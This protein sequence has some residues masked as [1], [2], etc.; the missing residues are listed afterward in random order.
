MTEPL[1]P[2]EALHEAADGRLDAGA[3]AALD[4][5]LAECDA[6]RA[7]LEAIRWTKAQVA[8]ARAE[9]PAPAELD[10]VLQ[11]VMATERGLA[12]DA[13]PIP[14]VGESTRARRPAWR[15]AVAA[16]GLAAALLLMVWALPRLFSTDVPAQV[17][18]RYQAL[19]AGTLTLGLL[20]DDVAEIDGWFRQ[21][22]LPFDARVFDL[23][24][25]R[26]RAVGGQV[27]DIDGRPSALFVYRGPD[28]QSL[29]CQMYE[30]RTAELPTPARR[31]SYNDIDFLV[32]ER[33][34]LTLVFWQE[35]KLVCVLTG[36]GDPKAVIDLAFAKAMKV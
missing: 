3:R 5:H 18:S 29:V 21:T 13:G 9:V 11:R 33:D 27:V 19:R 1:H 30:G 10:T 6:C 25:M 7:E 23:G 24:M 2:H 22:G 34:G 15:W 14:P 31:V 32:Y 36:E 16:T 17:A 8:A 35:G 12:P 4:R 20:T 26:Y 28:S